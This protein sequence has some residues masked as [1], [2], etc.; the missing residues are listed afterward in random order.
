MDTPEIFKTL[1]DAALHYSTINTVMFA[2]LAV[3]F[4]FLLLLF[5]ANGCAMY[6]HDKY[7][8]DQ[9]SWYKKCT[10]VG[11]ILLFAWNIAYVIS[12]LLFSVGVLQ[13]GLTYLFVLIC[14]GSIGISASLLYN[15]V[16]YIIVAPC[17]YLCRK[18]RK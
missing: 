8:L 2:G 15:L 5:F 9:A 14:A 13:V 11:T 4:S 17:L 7:D 12:A 16:W 10:T 18:K 1:A 6:V 3:V